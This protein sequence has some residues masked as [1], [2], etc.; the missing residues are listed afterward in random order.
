MFPEQRRK[1]LLEYLAGNGIADV[2]E[3]A[4]DLG[5]SPATI[6]RDLTSLE[7]AGRI[8]RTHGGAVMPYFSLAFEPVHNVKAGVLV[9]EKR[10]IAREAAQIVK[11]GEVVA[12]DSGSTTLCL[13][14]ELK[15]KRGLTI[16]TNDLNVAR[17]LCDVPTHEVVVIG[18]R[19][20]PHLYN[21]VGPFAEQVLS[22]IRANHVFLGADAIDLHDGITNANLDE[23]P[24]KQRMIAAGA[25]RVLLADHS[26]FGR[27]SFAKVADVETFDRIITD[28]QVTNDTLEAF[29]R[30]GTTLV[31]AKKE[32]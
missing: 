6:R 7:K 5:V 1:Q 23:V 31:V 2:H 16:V 9:E 18:G 10:A 24:I 14:L 20:R 26:K 15:H 22:A 29:D 12:L 8:K 13:A 27:V 28:W 11:D 19:V 32:A 3:L 30:L 4:K 17:E 21:L 25:N